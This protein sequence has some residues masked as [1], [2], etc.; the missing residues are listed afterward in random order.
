MFQV[1]TA[2]E[3]WQVQVKLGVARYAE[4]FP[5]CTPPLWSPEEMT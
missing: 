2:D 3:K 5:L 4:D 1:D